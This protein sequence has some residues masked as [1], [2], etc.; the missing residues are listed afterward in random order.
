MTGSLVSLYVSLV[1]GHVTIFLRSLSLVLGHSPDMF[2]GPEI[3][4]TCPGSSFPRIPGGSL[5]WVLEHVLL[6]PRTF[7]LGP[8]SCSQRNVPLFCVGSVP[9]VLHVTCS[10]FNGLLELLYVHVPG[11]VRMDGL[12][13]VVTGATLLRAHNGDYSE[14][15]DGY[16][17]G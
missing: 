17:K 8:V 7:Y 3:R 13:V 5:S 16:K 15:R 2:S 14:Q 10:L 9:L 12:V 11:S 1:L 6:G 4:F